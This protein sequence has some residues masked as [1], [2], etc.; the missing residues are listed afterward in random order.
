MAVRVAQRVCHG[1]D[2]GREG[3]EAAGVVADDLRFWMGD[4][5]VTYSTAQPV[6]R[7]RVVLHVGAKH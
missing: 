6:R 2:V 3:R 5:L 4:P 7:L 1:E